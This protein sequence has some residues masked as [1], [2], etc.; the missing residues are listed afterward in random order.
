MNFD[1]FTKLIKL[2]SAIYRNPIVL[3]VYTH[4]PLTSV[5]SERSFSDYKCIL[6]EGRHNLTVENNEKRDCYT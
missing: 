4:A 1:G 5:D 6:T 3:S 2:S